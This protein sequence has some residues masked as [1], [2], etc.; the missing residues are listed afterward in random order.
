M[1]AVSIYHTEYKKWKKYKVAKEYLQ[2]EY[3][4]KHFRNGKD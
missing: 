1:K 4:Q 2:R 3:G